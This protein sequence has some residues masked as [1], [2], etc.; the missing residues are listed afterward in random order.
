MKEA[1]GSS[2]TL[3]KTLVQPAGQQ[4]P[5]P[6]RDYIFE[7]YFFVDVDPLLVQAKA[8]RRKIGGRTVSTAAPHKQAPSPEIMKT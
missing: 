1:Y 5:G 3:L 4:H 6:N 8:D 2:H 7:T